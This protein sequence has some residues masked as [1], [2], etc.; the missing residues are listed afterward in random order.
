MTDQET[1]SP[2]AGAYYKTQ[3]G[4]NYLLSVIKSIPDRIEPYN[5]LAGA[6]PGT[7]PGIDIS[8]WQGDLS[9]DW[10]I[11]A[12]NEGYRFVFLKATEGLEF[13]DPKYEINKTNAQA[14]G[15]KVGAYHFARPEKSG[16]KQAEHFISVAGELDIGGV[17]DLED[18]GD[19]ADI[20]VN[21]RTEDFLS[22]LN[23]HYGY[24][25]MYSAAWFLDPREINPQV[26][27]YRWVAHWTTATEPYMPKIWQDREYDTWQYSDSEEV[28]GKISINADRMQKTLF[29]NLTGNDTN[30]EFVTIRLKPETIADLK[31]ALNDLGRV[32]P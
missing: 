30:A 20:V 29:D 10:W 14:A 13:I 28:A 23:D 6:L 11:T 8:H 12:Y 17:W 19:V 7:V 24:S 21:S 32:T 27:Y 3:W 15:I 5:L 1:K 2:H 18:D 22:T 25:W 31:R 4:F 26:P 9:P 16:I